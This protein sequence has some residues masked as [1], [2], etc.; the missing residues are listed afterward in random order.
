MAGGLGKF[1]GLGNSKI[2]R[3]ELE[4]LKRREAEAAKAKELRASI[5]KQVKEDLW[6]A[7]QN[8]EEE[9]LMFVCGQDLEGIWSISRI[10][11]LF[12]GF[13]WSHS[14]PWAR[15]QEEFVKVLSTLVWIGWDS[16]DDF[17]HLFLEHVNNSGHLDRTDK[18]L[19]LED[20]SFLEPDKLR[21]FFRNQQYIFIPVFIMEDDEELD[22][23]Y[24][25]YSEKHRMPFLGTEV[26]GEGGSGIVTKEI[27]PPGQFGFKNGTCNSKVLISIRIALA[28]AD[29]STSH[30]QLHGNAFHV[31]G[32]LAAGSI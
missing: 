21:T 23:E 13:D 32:L 1:F 19:P 31:R 28:C 16:W 25:Q 20:T 6:K 27:I 8:R 10:E 30:S 12:K 29:Y 9:H 14:R 4:A 17:G 24:M 5:V 15:I 2:K 18:H 11:Q 22:L 26:I 7:L 3:S